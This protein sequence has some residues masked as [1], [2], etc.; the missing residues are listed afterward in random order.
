LQIH[1]VS[2]LLGLLGP[3]GA[4]AC[5]EIPQ[6]S[7]GGPNRLA[8]HAS[9][10][11]GGYGL[12]RNPSY[13]GLVLSSLARA[14]CFRSIIGVLAT[15]LMIPPLVARIHA[16]ERLLAS[17]FGAEYEDYRRRTWRQM[18]WVY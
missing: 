13:V 6:S 11:T 2:M 5:A 17:Q 3:L 9:L 7:Q 15:L 14:L 18:P 12:V 16:E 1:K 4:S 8:G 10:V